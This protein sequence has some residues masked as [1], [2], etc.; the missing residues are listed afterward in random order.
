MAGRNWPPLA[1]T[2]FHEATFAGR[3]PGWAGG[4]TVAKIIAELDKHG[5]EAA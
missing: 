5:G 3:P 4:D 2:R 1:S